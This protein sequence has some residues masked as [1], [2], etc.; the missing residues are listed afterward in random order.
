[1]QTHYSFNRNSRLILCLNTLYKI[2]I[3]NIKKAL[4][5]PKE[6]FT[7]LSILRPNVFTKFS[8]Y[9]NRYCDPKVNKNISLINN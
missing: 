9:G 6:I 7:L 3:S 2:V 1:V 8:D 4:A 5:R